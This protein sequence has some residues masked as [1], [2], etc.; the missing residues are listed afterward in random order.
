MSLDYAEALSPYENKGVLGVPEQVDSAEA[1]EHKCEQLAASLRNSKNCMVFTGAGVSTASG[2]PDFRGPN[3]VWTLEK[4][5][6]KPESVDFAH[7]VPT[8]THFAIKELE[9][10]GIVKFLLT[11]NV[12]GLHVR[13]GFPL[14][15]HAE[16][17]GN[18]FAEQ[19]GK[20]RRKYYRDSIIPTIG[21]KP[22]GNYCDGTPEGRRCR[23][24]LHD[25]T[26]DWEDALPEPDYEKARWHSDLSLCIGTT[27]Q[28]LPVGSMPLQAKKNKNGSFV[29]INLQPTA[30]EKK[31]SLAI[32]AKCDEAMQRV[33][34]LLDI[35]VEVPDPALWAPEHVEY[36]SH[37]GADAWEAT[38]RRAR[39][40]KTDEE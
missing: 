29:T 36:S 28:I 30:H 14:D 17:H 31:A 15:R 10:R 16:L 38:K 24:K 8:Y 23:G 25:T 22:T 5:N 33:M 13:S 1:L 18:V 35:D 40:R 4:Q 32:H 7:A 26:L 2:I 21:L 6:R 3:G 37:P 9:K 27:L 20:C 11:Q 39:K 34:K 12:D 19:C